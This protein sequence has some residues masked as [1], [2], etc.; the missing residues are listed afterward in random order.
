MPYSQHST[1][2]KPSVTL[3]L[4][5]HQQNPKTEPRRSPSGAQRATIAS[6]VWALTPF[7]MQ[8]CT[9]KPPTW[10]DPG[11]ACRRRH[12]REHSLIRCQNPPVHWNSWLNVSFSSVLQWSEP[13]RCQPNLPPLPLLQQSRLHWMVRISV[14]LAWYQPAYASEIFRYMNFGQP[15]RFPSI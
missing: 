6:T 9:L 3:I 15:V 1:H 11:S 12:V 4:S 14:T 13:Q 8:Q 10:R 2:N 7:T 5:L